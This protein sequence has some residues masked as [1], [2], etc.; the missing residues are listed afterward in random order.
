MP[1]NY[2]RL[3]LLY[4]EK[5][6]SNSQTYWEA[7]KLGF[8]VK[9]VSIQ[10]LQQSMRNK[11]RY[12]A[13]ISD[14]IAKFRLKSKLVVLR[15]LLFFS[16]R[17]NVCRSLY[18]Y[19][20]QNQYICKN[21]YFQTLLFCGAAIILVEPDP[22]PQRDAA[23]Y[24]MYRF[25]KNAKNCISFIFFLFIFKTISIVEKK[26][27]TQMNIFSFFKERLLAIW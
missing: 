17:T 11:F 21:L 20:K 4:I 24:M 1:L 18:Y 25:R 2:S 12:L 9:I 19:Y 23:P 8:S 15:V 14:N 27:L 22:E 6:D 7:E 26:V 13:K 10:V 5:V 3:E 16:K